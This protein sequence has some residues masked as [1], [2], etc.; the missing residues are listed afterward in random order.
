VRPAPSFELSARNRLRG[1][2]ARLTVEGLMAEVVLAI[3]DQE[4]VAVITRSSAERLGLREGDPAF[5]IVKATE[6]LV[7]KE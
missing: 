7:G 1:R 6:V 2:I 4:V 3:G 5:A